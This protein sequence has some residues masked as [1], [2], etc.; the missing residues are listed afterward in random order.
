MHF[1]YLWYL[2]SILTV[3]GFHT[4]YGSSEFKEG[5]SGTLAMAEDKRYSTVRILIEGGHISAFS[6][7]FDHIPV[8]VVATDSGSNYVRFKRL[9]KNPNRFKLKD[10]FILAHLFGIPE[11]MMITLIVS[12]LLKNKRKK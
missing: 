5:I 1:P 3:G 2:L 12:Q 7:I 9:I 4:K 11:M 10:I 6:Q 8:S